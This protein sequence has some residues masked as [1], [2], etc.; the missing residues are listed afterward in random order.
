MSVSWLS[1][2]SSSSRR[3]VVLLHPAVSTNRCTHQEYITF[4]RSTG[5]DSAHRACRSAI[6]QRIN[7]SLALKDEW[8]GGRTSSAH[9]VQSCDVFPRSALDTFHTRLF[10]F[11][12]TTSGGFA[13]VVNPVSSLFQMRVGTNPPF[14]SNFIY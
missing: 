5:V 14:T 10:P 2:S 8:G 11:V 9:S 1:W 7:H 12:Q 6:H 4:S 13:T 3:G